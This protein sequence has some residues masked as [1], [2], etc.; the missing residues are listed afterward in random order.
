VFWFFSQAELFVLCNEVLRKPTF[1]D[2]ITAQET[3]SMLWLIAAE[4]S[5]EATKKLLKQFG[6]M[7]QKLHHLKSHNYF[8]FI[9]SVEF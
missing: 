6:S 2:K 1:L 7:V 9:T 4:T 3:L 5:N 8:R